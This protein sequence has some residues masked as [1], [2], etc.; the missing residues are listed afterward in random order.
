MTGRFGV[1]KGDIVVLAL[2]LVFFLVF[3]SFVALAMAVVW[4]IVFIARRRWKKTEN[5]RAAVD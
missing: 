3:Q 5:E 1:T 4:G 2:L